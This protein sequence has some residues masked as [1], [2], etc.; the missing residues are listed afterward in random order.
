[1]VKFPICRINK[2]QCAYCGMC[3]EIIFCPSPQACIGCLACFLGCPYQAR[4]LI[5]DKGPRRTIR[6]QINGRDFKV[7]EG[8]TVKRALEMVEYP[9]ARA[10]SRPPAAPEG[11]TPA[12]SWPTESLYA[13][14]YPP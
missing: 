7:P 8:I 11:A 12:W 13:P 1:M 2:D 3:E 6:I 9:P 5:E 10:T 14:V 4:E